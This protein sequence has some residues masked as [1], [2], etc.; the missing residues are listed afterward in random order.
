MELPLILSIPMNHGTEM[1]IALLVGSGFGFALERAGFGSADRIVPIFYFRDFRVLRVMFSAIVTAMLG[2]YLFDLAGWMPVSAIGILDTHYLPQLV[3]GLLLG[4]GFIIGGY[5]PGTSVVGAVS[6]KIDSMLF[7]LGI[8]GGSMVFTIAYPALESFHNS[9]NAGRVL[10]HEFFNVPSG[11]V[12]FAVVVM[13]VGAFIGAGKVED[14]V[15][16]KWGQK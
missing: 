3:G 14:L 15:R 5:C 4:A 1:L 2:L 12:V 13:A 16:E 9:G 6:G 11:V 7:I 10:I 8:F